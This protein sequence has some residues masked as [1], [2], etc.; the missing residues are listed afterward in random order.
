MSHLIYT[1]RSSRWSDVTTYRQDAGALLWSNSRGEGR[2]PYSAIREVHVYKV[3]YFG[4]R[5]TYWRCVLR[6][7]FGRKILLQAAH[8]SGARR[9]EDRTATYIPF[10][11][12]L[13]RKIAQAN[14]RAVFRKGRH[15]LAIVDAAIAAPFI[16]IQRATGLIG[17]DRAVALASWLLRRIGP[18]LKGH[19]IARAN[20]IASFPNKSAAEIDR[21]LAGMWDNIGRVFAEYAY[22]G[23]LWDC[24]RAGVGGEIIQ[25]DEEC[26]RRFL[27]LREAR[28]PA[29]LFGAHLA[30]WELLVWALG[31]HVGE[32]A[33][34]YRPPKIIAIERQLAKIRAASKVTYIPASAAAIFKIKNALRRGAW[35]GLLVD[36]HYPRGVD[37]EFFGRRCKASP[38][39]ARLARQFE[40]PIYGARIVRLS[41][42]KFRLDIT[43]P[44]AVCRDAAGRIDIPASTQ[45]MTGIIEGWVRD[46]PEQWLWLQRR[47]RS[48]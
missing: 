48:A 36:E 9:I 20:L 40:C 17:C 16:L 41:G 38:V 6:Y 26:R 2:V 1:V 11:K 25:F 35:V 8:H 5:A 18:R 23:R 45:V 39:V 24:D 27:E 4:S 10:I 7:G 31:S 12:A 43:E 47:W 34:V 22:L 13:E 30:N 3:R 42:G 14:P 33:V 21:I 28:G 29:L 46:H 32:T 44:V 15:W 19:R 37:V